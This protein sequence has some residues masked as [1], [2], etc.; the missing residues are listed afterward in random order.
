[1]DTVAA[2]HDLQASLRERADEI[3]QTRRL[4]KDLSQC[5]AEGHSVRMARPTVSAKGLIGN[6]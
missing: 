1:M 6:F 4:P 5:F 2:A 3:E